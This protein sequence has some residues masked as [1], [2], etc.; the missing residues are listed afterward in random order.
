[1]RVHVMCLWALVVF[2][3]GADD[4]IRVKTLEPQ[5]NDGSF[6]S[7]KIA[8]ALGGDGFKSEYRW[9]NSNLGLRTKHVSV[10]E[11]A[12]TF[13]DGV[14]GTAKKLTTSL[15]WVVRTMQQSPTHPRI[16][17]TT[18]SMRLAPL[19]DPAAAF[20]TIDAFVRKY[21]ISTRRGNETNVASIPILHAYNYTGV[22]YINVTASI[23]SRFAPYSSY[24]STYYA[25]SL[26][27]GILPT[28][29]YPWPWGSAVTQLNALVQLASS[30]S[31]SSSDSG[32]NET[33]A[34]MRAI[35]AS[36]YIVSGIP[37]P[38]SV[39]PR[40]S[41]AVGDTSPGLAF[42][43]YPAPA[44]GFGRSGVTFFAPS[45]LNRSLLV[46]DQLRLAFD[47]ALDADV[48]GLLHGIESP[49]STWYSAY[50]RETDELADLCLGSLVAAPTRDAPRLFNL[51]VENDAQQ[52]SCL[53]QANAYYF[54][55]KARAPR[56]SV[57]VAIGSLAAYVGARAMNVTRLKAA[58]RADRASAVK[59]A[60][61]SANATSMPPLASMGGGVVL[62]S[63]N[64]DGV[65]LQVIKEPEPM[66]LV[67][68]AVIRLGESMFLSAKDM[69]VLVACVA[70]QLLGHSC[71]R[72]V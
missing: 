29:T 66:H 50:D 57:S 17:D 46:I 54:R 8:S 33:L 71:S 27:N 55:V 53:W 22:T 15:A 40:T 35:W 26:P 21:N 49:S 52:P 41:L 3:D 34:A 42:Y 13:Y 43:A 69:D 39:A 11:L 60:V 56:R 14:V 68:R 65:V 28:T 44:A 19:L 12:R 10:G 32:A 59:T 38:P 1:M 47:D 7:Y 37:V 51:L 67:L 62:F 25:P 30:L 70:L 72:C 18:G 2:S 23:A 5:A 9:F 16:D 58:L 63:A 24:A 4:V 61:Q 64:D 36:F 6:Q 45:L 31:N 48:A 20:L